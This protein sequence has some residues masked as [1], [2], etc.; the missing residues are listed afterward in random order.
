MEPKALLHHYF[1]HREFRPGQE[2]LI[3]SILAGRD[4]LGVMPTS[5][6]KSVCYQVPAMAL[7]GMTLVISPLISLMANQVA[8]LNQAGIPAAYLSS[9]LDLED[10]RQI[11]RKAGMGAYKLLYVAPE[12]LFTPGFLAM[13]EQASISFVAVDEAHCVSQWGQDFR[14][15]YLKIPEFL[16]QLPTRP[17]LGAFTATA[18]EQVKAD[19]VSLLQL[20]DPL[21]LT[22]GFDR[23]NLYFGVVHTRQKDAWILDYLKKNPGKSGIIYCATRKNVEALCGQLQASGYLATRYHAGLSDWERKKNQ[24][25]FVYDRAR[26]MVATNAFGMGIDKSNVSFVLHYNMP[27]NLESYYQEAGRAGRDGEPASCILLFSPGDVQTA[28]FLILNSSDNQELSSEDRALLQERDLERLEKMERYCKTTDCLRQTILAY[29][30]QDTPPCGNCST[31]MGTYQASDITVEAQK[32][33]SGVARVC[34]MYPSGLRKSSIL[35]ML[36][37][38]RGKRILELNLDSLPT[39]GILKDLSQDRLNQYIDRLIEL[40][41]LTVTPTEFP[42]LLA[43]AKAG[44]VLFQGEKVEILLPV[45]NLSREKPVNEA[46]DDLLLTSLKARRMQLAQAEG[47]P[48]YIIFSNATLTDMALKRPMSMEALLEVSGVGKVKA[49]RYGDSFLDIIRTSRCVNL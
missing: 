37:G 30:G 25:D 4:V 27:K 35:Q 33:L 44:Q 46:P 41:Y 7:P 39:Y 10:Y 6:G 31:C 49:Q 17:V 29:F 14:P 15:S 12:R 13:I 36:R 45:K 1:G 5:A 23:P 3:Q 16:Q 40:E 22:T 43:T 19:I 24:E 28:K 42:V 34:R 26:V 21:T 47:V 38:S 48:A 8:S 32:I 18:T 2:P 20:Q 11:L 9:S